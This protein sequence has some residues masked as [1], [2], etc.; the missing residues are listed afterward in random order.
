MKLETKIE[1][2]DTSGDEGDQ[3]ILAL[4]QWRCHF[5]KGLALQQCLESGTVVNSS[6]EKMTHKFVNQRTYF[7]HL[8]RQRLV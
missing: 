4:W 5:W 6:V 7:E 2:D 3:M 1:L 8:C